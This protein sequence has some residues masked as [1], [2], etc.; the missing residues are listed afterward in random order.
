M[1][2]AHKIEVRPSSAQAEYINRAC[3]T[4]RHAYNQLLAHFSQAGVKW[5]KKAAYAHYIQ[6]I[7]PTYPW[8]SEVSSRAGR[9]AIDDL[10]NGFKHFFRRVKLGQKPGYPRFKR[11]D[12]NDSFAMREQPKFSVD[13]RLLRIE[14]MPGKLKLRQRVRFDGE[15]KQVT[16]SKQAGRF[17]ASILVE[18]EDYDRKATDRAP[19]VGVDFGISSLATLST[20]EVVP[21]NQAL[22]AN[23]RRLKRRNRNLSRKKAGSNR[24]A[25]AKLSL[26]KLHKRIADQR[27]AVLHET[28]DMLTRRF[29]TIVIEDLNVKG[30]V[31]NHCLARAISDAG[32]GTLRS[33]IEYKAKLRGNVVVLA[34]R[35]YPSSKTC[36]CCG[37]VKATMTLSDRMFCCDDCG[38]VITRDL[39]AAINL[40]RLHTLAAD[41]KRT[42][43]TSKTGLPA[44]LMTA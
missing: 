39:N 42:Q 13:G 10:D 18:T 27:K 32:F 23:L 35:F 6:V 43:E 2:L 21:S 44:L 9:N 29:D 25:K 11:K 17:Y 5:S 38:N 12:V 41:D 1:L 8:Y 15:A 37:S 22:K 30:M 31:K 20:G 36:S 7:R 40:K 14:K 3:G 24:R 33:M 26:A 34:D 16:I 28:S 4:R 19:V